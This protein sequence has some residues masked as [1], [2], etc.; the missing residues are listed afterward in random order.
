M[1]IVFPPYIVDFASAR[2][3]ERPD[4]I[5]DEGHT[6][7]DRIRD[8]FGDDDA[9]KV[10]DICDDLAARAGIYLLDPHPGNI[11]F[12]A[13]IV[14]FKEGKRL[15]AFSG[16]IF[17]TAYRALDARH[18]IRILLKSESET[19]LRST[20]SGSTATFFSSPR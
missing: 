3:D 9:P 15:A 14:F 4:L 13:R 17:S 7:H 10:I 20:R 5:E 2:F 11:K 16:L 18:P 19:L 1:Q 12:C 6:F 8:R